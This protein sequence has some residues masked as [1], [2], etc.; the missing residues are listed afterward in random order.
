MVILSSES[1]DAGVVLIG[2]TV[3]KFQLEITYSLAVISRE[4]LLID[5]TVPVAAM[6]K[7]VLELADARLQQTVG[8][9]WK[10]ESL[11]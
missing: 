4:G 8:W 10:L 6:T 2:P 7:P 5:S 3:R 9:R 1:M 11:Q